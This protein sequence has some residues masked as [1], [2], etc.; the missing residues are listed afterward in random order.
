MFLNLCASRTSV[1]SRAGAVGRSRDGEAVARP[2]RPGKRD[3]SIG[4]ELNIERWLLV[5]QRQQ[6]PVH[7]L[8]FLQTA[9]FVAVVHVDLA[10]HAFALRPQA[11]FGGGD[12]NP[13]AARP[14]HLLAAGRLFQ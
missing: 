12:K 11:L 14:A 3:A 9:P 7:A 5:F 2:R 8:P 10:A 4:L 6:C 1:S 13:V